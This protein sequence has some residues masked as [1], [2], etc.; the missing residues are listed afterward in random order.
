M[1]EITEYLEKVREGDRGA[2]DR[3]YQILYPEL[4]RLAQLRLA[5]MPPGSTLTPTALVN[6]AYLRLHIGNGLCP[7][8]RQHLM[9][10][11][12]RAM[13][14]ILVDHARRRHAAK[15]GDGKSEV[16]I[17]DAIAADA[18]T[19]ADLLDID[20]ALDRLE[21]INPAHRELVELRFFGGLSEEE[22]AEL[23]GVSTRTVRR[24]WQR[25][26]ALLHAQIGGL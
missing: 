20:R 17:T 4:K 2:L 16:T 6:E 26:R 7:A 15:R 8:D 24:D 13:R 25:A 18:S 1:A 12:A 22:I 21:E 14:F 11:A 19:P 3:V 5:R 10:C 23:R 9:A